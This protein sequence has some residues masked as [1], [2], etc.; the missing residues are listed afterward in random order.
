MRIED[1]LSDQINEVFWEKAYGDDLGTWMDTYPEQMTNDIIYGLKD[2]GFIQSPVE[3][4]LVT[5]EINKR[6]ELYD[7]GD[8]NDPRHLQYNPYYEGYTGTRK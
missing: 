7:F 1:Q 3:L 4:I 2:R 5:I 6:I 8:S